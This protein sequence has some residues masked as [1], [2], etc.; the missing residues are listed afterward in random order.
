MDIEERFCDYLLRYGTIIRDVTVYDKDD[1]EYRQYTIEQN[2][3]TWNLTK[4]HGEWI[5]LHFNG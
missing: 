3:H 4:H 2:G 5:Y 1:E